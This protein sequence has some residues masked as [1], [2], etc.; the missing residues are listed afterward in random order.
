MERNMRLGLLTAI[1]FVGCNAGHECGDCEG[2]AGTGSTDS[3][4]AEDCDS[5]NGPSAS[6]VGTAS[7]DGESV[8]CNL[9]VYEETSRYDPIA[10][11]DQITDLTL[12]SSGKTGEPLTGIPADAMVQ[13]WAGDESKEMDCGADYLYQED[14]QAAWYAMEFRRP[15]HYDQDG[16]AWTYDTIRTSFP[17]G[18]EPATF[19]LEFGQYLLGWFECVEHSWGWNDETWA[20]DIDHGENQFDPLLVKMNGT[21][22]WTDLDGAIVPSG[23]SGV[24]H[25]SGSSMTFAPDEDKEDYAIEDGSSYV[26]AT[27]F[28]FTFTREEV[29]RSTIACELV[30]T[31]TC[32]TEAD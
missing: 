27:S 16:N 18:D 12:V 3:T 7:I 24:F 28:G 22:I 15:L 4:C 5:E 2:S 11:E 8:D 14:E 29:G 13:V 25:T 10:D 31:A 9:F 32:D 19:S 6:A 30:E 21:A 23:G 26:T 17:E 20:Y 1:F